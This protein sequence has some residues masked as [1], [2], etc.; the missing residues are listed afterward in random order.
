MD[1]L[2]LD[3]ELAP[4]LENGEVI[5]AAPWEGRVFGMA[6]RLS[7]EGLYTWDEFRA[8]LISAIA[9]W[10]ADHAPGDEYRYFDHFLI[11]LQSVLAEKSLLDADA[12]QQ[13]CA[14]FEARPHGHDH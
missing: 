10:E 14:E 12:V 2:L 11:A 1:E 7:E 8:H 13:R 9:D 3:R 5:F 4:P 6:R